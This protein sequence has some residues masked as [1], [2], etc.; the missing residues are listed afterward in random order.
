MRNAKEVFSQSKRASEGDRE[1]ERGANV[2][3]VNKAWETMGGEFSIMDITSS[4]TKQVYVERP[5]LC[6]RKIEGK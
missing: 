2:W 6:E 5:R 3:R 1:R 4:K